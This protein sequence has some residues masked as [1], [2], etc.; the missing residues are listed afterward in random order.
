MPD[1]GAMRFTG[2]FFS[3]VPLVACAVGAT[4]SGAVL[5]YPAG[6]PIT[7]P[8]ASSISPRAIVV[9][10]AVSS[11]PTQ[12]AKNHGRDAAAASGNRYWAATSRLLKRKH[13]AEVRNQQSRKT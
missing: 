7:Q 4:A 2:N 6:S 1:V 8:D 12:T 11:E 5:F 10:N 3:V 13:Q 9:R